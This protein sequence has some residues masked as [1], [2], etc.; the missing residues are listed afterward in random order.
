RSLVEFQRH[1][2]PHGF[3]KEAMLPVY[4]LAE[5]SLA[6]T[7][8]RPGKLL[9]YEVVDRTALADGRVVPTTGRGSIALVGVGAPVPGHEVK[10]VD[11]HGMPLADREVGH[12]VVRGPSVMWGYYRDTKATHAVLKDGWLWTGDLGYFVEGELFVT[13]RAKDLIIVRGRNY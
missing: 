12:I 5:A 8:S 4:G 6:V 11:D 3:K 9:R 1:F 13:G 2:E 10:V 7:F